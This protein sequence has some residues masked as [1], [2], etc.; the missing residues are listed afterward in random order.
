MCKLRR[1]Y[2]EICNESENLDTLKH[3]NFFLPAG[4]RIQSE[5]D[6][7]H[8][9]TCGFCYADTLSSIEDY[10]DYYARFNFY[11]FLNVDTSLNNL[12]KDEVK[13]EFIHYF[14]KNYKILDLGFGK[15]ELLLN[16]KSEGFN[17]LYG[18]D[19]C[20]ESVKNARNNGIEANV[21][22]IYNLADNISEKM[23]IIIITGVLEHLIKP[24]FALNHSA[25]YL[26][27]DG[28][29]VITVPNCENL[30]FDKSPL[31]NNFN[32][33]HINYFSKVSLN[34]IMSKHG[35]K[36][37]KVID[38]INYVDIFAIFQFHPS[39]KEGIR[40]DEV[41]V[42]SIKK[43][44]CRKDA[45]VSSYNDKLELYVKQNKPV[46]VW[47][48]GSFAMSLL[49]NSNLQN[50]N[51]VA[52]VDNNPLKCGSEL[53]NKQIVL[54]KDIYKFDYAD[55]III[56]CIKDSESIKNQI[57]EMNCNK[58]IIIL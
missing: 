8:C 38:D 58:E 3:I 26:K 10:D 7:I 50:C 21:G 44:F 30:Q 18:V 24:S 19:P 36:P 17:N 5:Y 37:I 28:F 49:S 25:K 23:D 57:I 11:S 2:C 56:C 40:V 39:N 46:L 29:L 52:F 33:E 15:A 55:T 48:T 45:E 34:N 13:K 12:S 4:Y 6:V 54:P 51:I 43:Y 35:F 14:N 20:L 41:T 22:S 16:L 32:Q 53:L 31:S 1:R 9:K 42:K 47:G 27:E